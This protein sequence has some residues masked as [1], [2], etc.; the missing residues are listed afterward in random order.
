M[1]KVDYYFIRTTEHIHRVQKNMLT[2]VTEFKSEL[3]LSDENCRQLM[4][5]VMNHDRSKYSKQQFMP[6]IEL[7]EYYRQRKELKNLEYDYPSKEIKDSVDKAVL[8]HYNNE[9]H[10]P[11]IANGGLL[12]WDIYNA[13]ETVCDLQAMAQEFNEGVCRNYYENVWKPKQAKHFYD[14][15]NWI[16]VTTIMNA[17]IELFEEKLK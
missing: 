16:Q 8:H 2:V 17:V 6:Y 12:K 14:D 15:F 3:N 13:I 10:H 9:N 11:E 4:F 7:T 5:N 1:N